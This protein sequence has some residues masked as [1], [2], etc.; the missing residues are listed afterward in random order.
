[1]DI[2]HGVRMSG[3]INKK[4]VTVVNK[5]GHEH[6]IKIDNEIDIRYIY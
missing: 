6:E 4:I 1:M 2:T 3:I 5:N